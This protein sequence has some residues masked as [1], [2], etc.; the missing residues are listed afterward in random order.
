MIALDRIDCRHHA[1]LDAKNKKKKITQIEGINL[2]IPYL[3]SK[4][5]QN[6]NFTN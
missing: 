5:L 2:Q 3:L 6:Q 4:Y 1:T